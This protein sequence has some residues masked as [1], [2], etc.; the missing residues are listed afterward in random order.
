MERE[1]KTVY[2]WPQALLMVPGI[3][4]LTGIFVAQT[5]KSV[6][7]PPDSI[8][9]CIS[10]YCT[11]CILFC[12]CCF[13]LCLALPRYAAIRFVHAQY[14]FALCVLF[15]TGAWNLFYQNEYH[16]PE[17]NLRPIT[18]Y[19]KV[20][21][22]ALTKSGRYIRIHCKLI[23][24]HQD[25]GTKPCQQQIFAYLPIAR[26]DST[27]QV[28]SHILMA[29]QIDASAKP[30]S[31]FISNTS[32]FTHTPATSTYPARLNQKLRVHLKEHIRD[33]RSFALLS[34]L[35]VGNKDDFDADLKNAYSSTGAMHVL[36]VS[37]LHV[38]IVYAFLLFFFDFLLPG[39]NRK[40]N[41]LKQLLILI[42]LTSFAAIA[43][44]STS[45]TRA[46]LMT[47]S[48]TFGRLIQRQ[49]NTHQTLFA[50]AVLICAANPSAL[51]EVSFQLSFSAVFAII[52]L[53]PLIQNLLQFRNK[54][55]RYIWSL[56]TVSIAAQVG[57]FPFTLY[58]FGSFPY[59][60]LITNLW[61][62]PLTGILIY[63]LCTWLILGQV[64]YIGVA[65]LWLLEQL[66]WIM[67][68]GVL[69]L[70]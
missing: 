17:N 8:C 24:F 27:L 54:L 64:P 28:G 63:L 43:G 38:G 45:I 52:T 34:G 16:I 18:L 42:G 49:I 10:T 61:V 11:H 66:A 36:A 60:F 6:F 67:N 25:N 51:F 58:Y 41:I 29:T 62:I 2:I 33:P 19:A 55:L 9:S 37:G 4:F 57:T 32:F 23:A 48:L 21:R 69:F 70:A 26:N 7:T 46:L 68:Q 13:I 5:V 50:T 22:V 1:K 12:T 39:N 59:L 15:F 40:R 30:P 31:A 14:I 53:Q 56:S 47:A 35:S 20:E 65:L 3:V 44:F